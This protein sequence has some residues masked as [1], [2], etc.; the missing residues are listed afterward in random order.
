M[1]RKPCGPQSSHLDT[2][3]DVHGLYE[4]VD[5]S[6]M[7]PTQTALSKQLIQQVTERNNRSLVKFMETKL[8]QVVDARLFSCRVTHNGVTYI[9]EWRH[10]PTNTH[11]L[12]IACHFYGVPA[13]VFVEDETEYEAEPT[14]DFPFYSEYGGQVR[15]LVDTLHRYLMSRFVDLEV[16][17]ES[18]TQR[19]IGVYRRIYKPYTGVAS[20]ELIAMIAKRRYPKY[21]DFIHTLNIFKSRRFK[22]HELRLARQ[23][24]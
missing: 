20:V 13:P 7:P 2:V 18:Q 11:I 16:D 14:L 4:I 1:R 3:P 5:T 10:R 15:K 19:E 23:A 21:L 6:E 9:Q 12:S 8:P 24:D 17:V 22:P